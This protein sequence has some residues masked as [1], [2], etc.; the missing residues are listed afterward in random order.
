MKKNVMNANASVAE[1]K[2]QERMNAFYEVFNLESSQNEAAKIAIDY[3]VE[4]VVDPDNHEDAVLGTAFDF[5][6][7]Y[8]YARNTR[9]KSVNYM[10][11]I[12]E[13]MLSKGV[14]AALDLL[15]VQ[16]KRKGGNRSGYKK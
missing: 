5:L 15:N 1:A 2:V 11:I 10:E 16:K 7:G 14:K 12:E 9:N 4:E 8:E 13:V 6:S 3:A